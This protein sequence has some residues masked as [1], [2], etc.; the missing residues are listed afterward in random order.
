MLL[1]WNGKQPE[2]MH[3]AHISLTNHVGTGSS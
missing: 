2:V 1:K 3:S